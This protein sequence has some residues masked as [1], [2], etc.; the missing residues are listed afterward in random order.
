MIEIID[1]INNTVKKV[2]DLE[3]AI[4]P[5]T[6]Q[7]YFLEDFQMPG[8]I[9]YGVIFDKQGTLFCYGNIKKNAKKHIKIS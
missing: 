7:I 2:K 4:H 3:V 8:Q 9:I 1:K 6:N 5:L